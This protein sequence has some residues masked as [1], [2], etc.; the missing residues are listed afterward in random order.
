[1]V[2][3]DATLKYVATEVEFETMVRSGRMEGREVCHTVTTRAAPQP[4][5]SK[6]LLTLHLNKPPQG[7]DKAGCT[8]MLQVREE[9]GGANGRGERCSG[10]D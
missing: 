9:S 3:Q 2:V 5:K 1:M 7:R 4:H 6:H 8:Y 10:C